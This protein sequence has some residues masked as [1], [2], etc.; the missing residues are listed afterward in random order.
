MK[1]L[2]KKNQWKMLLYKLQFIEQ[3]IMGLSEMV[4]SFFMSKIERPANKSQVEIS[5]F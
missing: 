5:D 2:Q 1:K 4:G 3:T